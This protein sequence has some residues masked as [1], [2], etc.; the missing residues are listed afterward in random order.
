MI[1]HHKHENLLKPFFSSS[2][3]SSYSHHFFFVDVVL[4]VLHPIHWDY[5]L[6]VLIIYSTHRILLFHVCSYFLCSVPFSNFPKMKTKKIP[7]HDQRIKHKTQHNTAPFDVFGWESRG[8]SQIV[9]VGRSKSNNFNCILCFWLNYFFSLLVVVVVPRSLF[10]F[11][12]APYVSFLIVRVLCSFL[13]CF[14]KNNCS[15]FIGSIEM[16]HMVK[17][18]FK[19]YFIMRDEMIKGKR[20]IEWVSQSVSQSVG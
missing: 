10:L 13:G 17:S 8:F 11:T 5:M 1:W 2:H 18:G 9:T 14:M 12:F 6:R 4:V 15:P 20:D 19:Y 7:L 16:T 3:Y